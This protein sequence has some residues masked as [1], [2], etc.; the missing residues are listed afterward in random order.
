ML[1]GVII[2]GRSL[3]AQIVHETGRKRSFG[4]DA[5]ELNH[6]LIPRV[7]TEIQQSPP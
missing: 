3:V 2:E 6:F 1:Y 7:S 5:N 4:Q